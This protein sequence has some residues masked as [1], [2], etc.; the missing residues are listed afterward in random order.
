MVEV[1]AQ[2]DLVLAS[3]SVARAGVLRAAGVSFRQVAADIDERAFD[4]LAAEEGPEALVRALASAKGEAVLA[5][6]R[7]EGGVSPTTV[8]VAADQVGWRTPA[9]ELLHKAASAGDAVAMLMASSD[10]H[11]ALI[12]GVAV[13][14]AGEWLTAF[15]RAE[16]S[17]APID[18]DMAEAYVREARPFDSVGAL[19]LEDC[20]P[21]GPWPFVRSVAGEWDGV[22]GLPM[23]VVGPLIRRRAVVGRVT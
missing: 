7:A 20:A 8:I 17:M 5:R 19:R 10:G 11:I 3:A 16:V 14:K 22:M 13:W 21:H 12:N 18:R 9:G 1:G 15:D 4:H 23:E 6:L 2:V